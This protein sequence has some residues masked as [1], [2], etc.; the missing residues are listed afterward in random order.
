LQGD[1]KDHQGKNRFSIK[2][3][4]D[5]TADKPGEAETSIKYTETGCPDISS[6]VREQRRISGANS[7]R[8]NPGS[9]EKNK[10]RKKRGD[11]DSE[12]HNR[13]ASSIKEFPEKESGRT[14]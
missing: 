8:R 4:H 9:A 13:Y 6:E 10:R 5:P 7:G 1:R 14:A 11:E 12:N 3:A 2:D